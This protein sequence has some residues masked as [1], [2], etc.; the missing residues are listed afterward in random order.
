MLDAALHVIF[1]T[2]PSMMAHESP[3]Q[4]WF[5]H[6]GLASSVAA[7]PNHPQEDSVETGWIGLSGVISYC[8]PFA[9]VSAFS[10]QNCQCGEQQ[11]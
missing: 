8:L 1:K 9:P 2:G 6:R 7:C 3:A 4:R 5:C 10:F 11:D